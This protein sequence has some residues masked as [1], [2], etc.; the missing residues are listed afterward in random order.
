MTQKIL[1]CA[2]DDKK[3]CAQDDKKRR[4]QDDKKSC[5]QEYENSKIK[6]GR[7]FFN[8]GILSVNL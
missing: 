4:A 3:S 1:R 6:S 2:Q 8:D 5:A 7:V